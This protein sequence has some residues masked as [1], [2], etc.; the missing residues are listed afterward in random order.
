MNPKQVSTVTL[1]RFSKAVD[2]WE[3]SCSL[4]SSFLWEIILG[5]GNFGNIFIVFFKSHNFIFY[6]NY[7]KKKMLPKSCQSFQRNEID[8][9]LQLHIQFPSLHETPSSHFIASS[10]TSFSSTISYLNAWMSWIFSFILIL[11]SG[12]TI[13]ACLVFQ[14]N[15]TC[16]S[17]KLL[18]FFFKKNQK[19]QVSGL[20]T[21]LG[22]LANECYC[23]YTV[24]VRKLR[25]REIITI[26]E[27]IIVVNLF[28]FLK[29][30]DMSVTEIISINI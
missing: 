2:S 22:M 28:H 9:H 15:Y 24:Q 16:F 26:I 25:F 19:V 23:A 4:I 20:Y 21:A 29:Y 11:S 8:F 5:S 12:F 6:P 27:I 14:W 30:C 13:V 7:S 1:E 17:F 10:N 18:F 3:K